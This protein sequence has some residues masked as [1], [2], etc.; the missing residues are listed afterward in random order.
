MDLEGLSSPRAA[1][2]GARAA[3]VLALSLLVPSDDSLVVVRAL[4]LRSSVEKG[5]PF[6][7][8]RLFGWDS[9][10][11]VSAIFAADAGEEILEG[12]PFVKLRRCERECVPPLAALGRASWLAK[13]LVGLEEEEAEE[14]NVTGLESMNSAYLAVGAGGGGKVSS[15]IEWLLSR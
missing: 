1:D 12:C 9:L 4:D 6:Y 15:R 13:R 2:E 14:H 8:L 11:A 3:H 5:A 10:A 7:Y